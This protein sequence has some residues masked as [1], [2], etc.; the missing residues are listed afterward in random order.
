MCGATFIEPRFKP[1]DQRSWRTGGVGAT[2]VTGAMPGGARSPSSISPGACAYADVVA[3]TS[4]AR[5]SPIFMVTLFCAARATPSHRNP[6]RSI[7]D[8]ND[9]WQRD[10]RG[11]LHYD[12]RV[13]GRTFAI[14][15]IHG[16]LVAL[17]TLFD[18]LPELVADDTVVFLGDYID[19]GPDS[20]GVVRWVRELSSKVAAKVVC[21]RGNHEDAWLQVA[22][23]GWP[24]FI[25][26]RGNGCLEC[27]RSFRNLPVPGEDDVPTAE[28]YEEMLAAKFFP[29]EGLEWMKSLP[30]FYEDEHA[31]Y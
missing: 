28:E 6:A 15:D 23:E 11:F 5:T 29:P 8:R 14:G 22:T 12:G 10:R 27:Y 18:R 9:T 25:M 16:D 26:P 20:A 1:T 13:S 31:I 4:D 2:T 3:I 30:Y 24:E 7:V 19:R 21:L 17:A